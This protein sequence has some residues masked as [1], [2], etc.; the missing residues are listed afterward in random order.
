MKIHLLREPVDRKLVFENIL[1][2]LPKQ[3][4]AAAPAACLPAWVRVKK[5]TY[6]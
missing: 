2:A 4:S 1:I 5:S 6:M 3:Q